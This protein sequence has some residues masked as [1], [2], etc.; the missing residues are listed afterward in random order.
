MTLGLS[1]RDQGRAIC[2]LRE[3]GCGGLHALTRQRA[4]L[5]KVNEVNQEFRW[6]IFVF[7]NQGGEALGRP[8]TTS[9]EEADSQD[10][11]NA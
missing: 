9:F 8:S 1:P 10:T 6:R 7:E 4:F 11:H 3:G 2:A 5:A